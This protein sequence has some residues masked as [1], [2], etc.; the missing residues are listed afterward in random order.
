MD[1]LTRWAELM[2]RGINKY[3]RTSWKKSHSQEELDKFKSSAFRHFIQ[4]IN[5][6]ED[7][8]DHGA[9]VFFNI[10]TVEMIKKK[11]NKNKKYF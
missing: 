9:A 8:E 7:G 10:A 5:E 3:G 1:M 4:W 6:V 2:T 11:L